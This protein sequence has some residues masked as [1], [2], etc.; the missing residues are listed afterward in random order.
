MTSFILS[1][2][3]QIS[4]FE[5]LDLG[6]SYIYYVPR[7]HTEHVSQVWFYLPSQ[8][9][10]G[11][12]ECI[13]TQFF[14]PIIDYIYQYFDVI[15]QKRNP[16]DYIDENTTINLHYK[17]FIFPILIKL[18]ATTSYNVFTL[19][20]VQLDNSFDLFRDSLI[21]KNQLELILTHEPHGNKKQKI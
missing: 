2:D 14:N 10:I 21:E 7:Q 4:V 11:N 15:N 20:P 3:E 16:L 13:H 9:K 18:V 5:F 6:F 1:L 17:G 12:H 19:A 8:T